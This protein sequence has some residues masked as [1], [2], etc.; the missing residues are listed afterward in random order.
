MDYE[1]RAARRARRMATI[2][3]R[4][5]RNPSKAIGRYIEDPLRPGKM[6]FQIYGVDN[7]KKLAQDTK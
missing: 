4:R 5:G 6:L 1:K 7:A 2:I 3:K